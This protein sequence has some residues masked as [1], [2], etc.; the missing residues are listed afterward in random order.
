MYHLFFMFIGRLLVTNLRLIWHSQTMPR[1][2]LC[3]L[4]K[5]ST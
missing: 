2:N 5:L 1:I 4:T 3:K